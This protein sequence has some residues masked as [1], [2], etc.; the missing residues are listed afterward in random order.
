MMGCGFNFQ[1]A[2]HQ[3][4]RS[5]SSLFSNL[6][7]TLVKRG[8]KG[9]AKRGRPL[10]RVSIGKK[11][12]VPNSFFGP[13]SLL[14]NLFCTALLEPVISSF[15]FGHLL[16]AHYFHRGDP[17]SHP[18]GS[19]ARTEKSSSASFF[20]SLYIKNFFVFVVLAIDC[21][22][23]ATARPENVQCRLAFIQLVRAL[24]SPALICRAPASN[25][26]LTRDTVES[27]A[28]LFPTVPLRC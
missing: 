10:G 18:S 21:A 12:P 14:E 8:R 15:D 9:V 26:F 6:I 16:D 7:W 13:S 28:K 11:I 17:F 2:S 19:S 20:S 27:P 25:T 4:R 24:V 23:P 1:P 22:H 3:R 5:F